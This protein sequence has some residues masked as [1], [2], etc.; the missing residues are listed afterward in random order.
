M[1]FKAWL[2]EQADAGQRERVR[3]LEEKARISEAKAGKTLRRSKKHVRE[4]ARARVKAERLA[5]QSPQGLPR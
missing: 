2:N 4:A 5:S 1:S 3:R